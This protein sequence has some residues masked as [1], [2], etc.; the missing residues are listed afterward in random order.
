[1]RVNSFWL[2]WCV[3]FHH[4]YSL[5][6]LCHVALLV[7]GSNKV[8]QD[9]PVHSGKTLPD[10]AKGQ[11]PLSLFCQLVSEAL[12]SAARRAPVTE[13]WTPQGF[14]EAQTKTA[15]MLDF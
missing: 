10:L 2:G 3:W 6:S 15:L 5:E 4:A 9:S 11:V 14:C 1:V 12:S 8:Q 7:R 13:K